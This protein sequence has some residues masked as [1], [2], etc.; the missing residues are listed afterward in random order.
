MAL[1]LK[2]KRRIYSDLA[3]FLV[4]FG[5]AWWVGWQI[6][7]L[8]WSLWLSSLLVGYATI[9]GSILYFVAGRVE[10]PDTTSKDLLE[11]LP[12]IA[13]LPVG[14]YHLGF[15]SIHF[16]GFHAVHA[17]FLFAFFPPEGLEEITLEGLEELEMLARRAVS[18]LPFVVM[19]AIG[20]RD[21]IRRS[22]KKYDLAGPYLNVVRMHLLIFFFGFTSFL[23]VDHIFVFTV[24]YVVYFSPWAF[25]KN[26]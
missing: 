2:D 7:D 1:T 5:V 25:E 14:L 24:V 23:G 8:I 18:Y 20:E 21:R 10:L 22:V 26:K 3:V 17:F 13:R 15:F 19:L 11:G 16:I 4:G 12:Q 9:I 6:E